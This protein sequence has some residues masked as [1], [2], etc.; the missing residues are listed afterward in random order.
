M[1]GETEDVGLCSSS[2]AVKAK[3]KTEDEK[4]GM[5]ASKRTENLLGRS[6]AQGQANLHTQSYI[7]RQFYG[8]DMYAAALPAK[9]TTAMKPRKS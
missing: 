8:H 2:R 9:M 4:E 1:Y 7:H 6:S 5:N 3:S